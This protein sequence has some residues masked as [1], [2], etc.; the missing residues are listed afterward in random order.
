MRTDI[1]TI[2]EIVGSRRWK[3]IGHVLQ[4]DRNDTPRVALTW[5]PEGRR[6]VGRPKE[7]WKR[8]VEEEQNQKGYRT[9]AEA[10]AAAQDRGTWRRDSVGPILHGETRK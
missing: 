1:Q 10:Q 4:M 9:L 6:K 3:W 8:T 5:K 2:S 7:N